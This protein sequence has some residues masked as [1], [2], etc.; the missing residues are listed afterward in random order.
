MLLLT[1]L[2]EPQQTINKL[3]HTSGYS[4]IAN[5]YFSVTHN[6]PCDLKSYEALFT[7]QSEPSVSPD[8]PKSLNKA[9]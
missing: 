5:A 7:T 1:K 6:C 3:C 9:D 2:T 8:D 4:W